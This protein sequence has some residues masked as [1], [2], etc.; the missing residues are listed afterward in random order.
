MESIAYYYIIFLFQ[1]NWYWNYS[2]LI[3][4]TDLKPVTFVY[5]SDDSSLNSLLDQQP[6][7]LPHGLRVPPT[8][9]HLCINSIFSVL[10]DIFA[11]FLFEFHAC[12][13][14]SPDLPELPTIPVDLWALQLNTRNWKWCSIPSYILYA[15][16][17]MGN[18]QLGYFKETFV[19]GR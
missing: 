10:P 9:V 5:T 16:K 3:I 18:L 4:C 8:R 15:V 11:W 14:E 2:I 19:K 17:Y 12:R 7:E 1:Y 13:F 6:E